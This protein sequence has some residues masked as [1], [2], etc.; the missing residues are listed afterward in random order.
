M[1]LS[2][3]HGRQRE[4]QQNR[5]EASVQR[6]EYEG[7]ASHREAFISGYVGVRQDSSGGWWCEEGQGIAEERRKVP[8]VYRWLSVVVRL[9][10]P[11]GVRFFSLALRR[12]FLRADRRF[13]CYRD[14][15]VCC[16]CSVS[17]YP[18]ECAPGV[19]VTWFC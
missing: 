17:V 11:S 18:F 1:V 7:V 19:P 8:P 10:P 14:S 12:D 2:D 13:L 15:M 4:R 3:R 5:L 9:T 6:V 16:R